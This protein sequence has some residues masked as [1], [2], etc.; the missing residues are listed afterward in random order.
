MRL[1][2][3]R[4]ATSHRAG[5]QL[6]VLRTLTCNPRIFGLVTCQPP[7]SRA[8]QAFGNAQTVM[9]DNSSR[10]GKYMELQF[11]SSGTVKGASLRHYLLEKSRVCFQNVGE[12]NYHVFAQFLAGAD[13]EI[14]NYCKR[15]DLGRPVSLL[16]TRLHTARPHGPSVLWTYRSSSAMAVT[17]AV[18]FY[19]RHDRGAATA[20]G[21]P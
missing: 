4:P 16:A 1:A 13:S 7:P 8:H 20:T 18:A 5:D 14:R 21:A 3:P 10:F 9:N 2:S 6:I 12:H 17:T 11:T 19:A 15:A